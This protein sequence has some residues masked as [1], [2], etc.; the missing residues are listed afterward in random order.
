MDKQKLMEKAEAALE[1]NL[2]ILTAQDQPL[3]VDS[4]IKAVSVLVDMIE[5]LNMK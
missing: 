2:D 1:K 3:Q 4:A 5:K